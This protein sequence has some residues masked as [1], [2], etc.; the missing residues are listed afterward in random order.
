MAQQEKTEQG[1]DAGPAVPQNKS[2]MAKALPWLIVVAAPAVLAATGFLVG[3]TFG[4]RAQVAS[5]G[6]LGSSE[7]AAKSFDTK[8]TKN[9]SWFYDLDPV[10]ANL[11]EPGVTRYVRVSLTLEIT[12]A[13]P[14]EEAKPFMDQKKPLMKHWLTLYLANLTMDEARGE[15]NLVRIQN[16]ICEALNQGLFPDGNDQIKDVLLREF[17]IQ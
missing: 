17:A 2:P 14:Q 9:E 4:T 6:E 1:K 11:N 10:V 8:K 7:A 3:R 12:T 5:A 15:R 16:H 13:W